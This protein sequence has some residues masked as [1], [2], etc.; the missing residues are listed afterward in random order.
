MSAAQLFFFK[1]VKKLSSIIERVQ[2]LYNMYN[3]AGAEKLSNFLSM[4][5]IKFQKVYLHGN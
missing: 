1:G 3:L 2:I 4:E 5:K